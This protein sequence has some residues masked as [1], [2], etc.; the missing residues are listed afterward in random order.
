MSEMYGELSSEKRAQENLVCRQIV[1]EIN[2][3][4]INQRQ[5]IMLIYLLSL[6]IENAETMQ[7]IASVIREAAG[8]AVFLTEQ[9]SIDGSSNS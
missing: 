9:G 7:V 2:N 4:G 8:S 6:E 5:L 1:S 3:F